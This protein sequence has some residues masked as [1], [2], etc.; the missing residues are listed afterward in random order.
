M[1]TFYNKEDH[2]YACHY[3]V[4]THPLFGKCDD[5]PSFNK[6][7]LAME[8]IWLL[9]KIRDG[10]VSYETLPSGRI[11]VTIKYKEEDDE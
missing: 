8:Q 2:Y 3:N 10:E 5:C 7:T 1:Q 6:C 11:R 9:K 4:T